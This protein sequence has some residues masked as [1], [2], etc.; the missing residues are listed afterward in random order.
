MR[1]FRPIF[2]VGLAASIAS[3]VISEHVVPWSQREFQKTQ[4]AMFGFALANSPSLASNRVFVYQN[5]N[6]YVGGASKDQ[7]NTNVYHLSKVL[8]I[9]NPTDLSSFPR[10]FTAQTADY[11]NGLWTLYNV[12]VHTEDSSGFTAVE[13]HPQS[14]TLD[15]RIP[16]PDV[17]ADANGMDEQPESYTMAELRQKIDVMSKTGIDTREYLVAYQFKVA[18]PFLCLAFAICAPPLSMTFARTGSFVGVFLTVVMFFVA[19]N[20]LILAKAFGIH[21]YLSPWLAAWLA[22]ILF[23]GLGAFLLRRME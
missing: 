15:L 6:F 10:F 3:F 7:L 20:T 19:W 14:M 5:Y 8:I 13:M 22:N 12:V 4:A 18:L 21:G 1:I 16:L 17:G 11:D 23:G 2:A 9:E